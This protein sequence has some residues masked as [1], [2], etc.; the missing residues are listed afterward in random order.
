M[1][2][3]SPKNIEEFRLD[4]GFRVVL[5]NIPERISVA[6]SV[7]VPIGSRLEKK[8]EMGYS[9]FVE[10]MLFK[11][12]PTRTYRD[13]SRQIERLGGDINAAT[14][15]ELTR[16]YIKINRKFIKTAFEILSDIFF[17]SEF[18]RNEFE[19]EKKVILEELKMGEDSPDEY[20]FESFYKNLFGKETLGQ[21][22]AGTEG[23]ISKSTQ[24]KLFNFYQ[25]NYGT[26]N[27]VLSISGGLWKG[28]A[29][30]KAFIALLRN[31]FDISSSSL[32]GLASLE[33]LTK[34]ETLT[35]GIFHERKNLEQL[36]FAIGLPGVSLR[37]ENSADIAI[38]SQLM[39]GS[40]SSRLFRKLREEHGFCYSVSAFQAGYYNEGLWGVYV[41]TSPAYLEKAFAVLMEELKIALRGEIPE[42]E[43][44]EAKS[45][46]ASYIEL[47]MET[48]MRRAIYNANSLFFYGRL[49]DWRERV[50]EIENTTADIVWQTVQ[51][52][53]RGEK[54]NFTS[55]GSPTANQIKKT[56][57][58]YDFQLLKN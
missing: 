45:G 1:I 15:R 9:H 56:I 48:P 16:Y 30:K 34:K 43:V 2:L 7:W 26:Q 12:T 28:Y 22:I 18:P 5:E 25:R 53:W 41:G 14:S 11:G 29:E 47:S 37:K 21:P 17:N 38:F 42:V 27:S 57:G 10:H 49:R 3:F 44:E 51:D 19:T 23:S 58:K 8:T 4:N 13:I 6:T 36:H 31:Y 20:L 33:L 40:M 52:L 54:F 39:G 55:L 32:Q 50:T 46:L 24:K 35:H